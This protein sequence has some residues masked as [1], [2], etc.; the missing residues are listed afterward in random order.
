[1][2]SIIIYKFLQRTC[3]ANKNGSLPKSPGS[4]AHPDA[5]L[6]KSGSRMSKK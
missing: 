4:L 1:M 2:T 5:L 3:H 6:T